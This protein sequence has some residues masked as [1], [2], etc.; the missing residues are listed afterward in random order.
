MADAEA[1]AGAGTQ[2]WIDAAYSEDGV[3][4][5]TLGSMG[6]F[7]RG[8]QRQVNGHEF[9]ADGRLAKRLA[10]LSGG[11]LALAG[12]S[13][14]RPLSA[15]AAWSLANT[16]GTGDENSPFEDRVIALDFSP[17]GEW[18]ATGGGFPSRGGEIYIWNVEDG[19][20]ELRILEAHSDTVCSLAFSPDGS[21]LASGGTIGSPESLRRTG[22][23]NFAPWKG[24]P[25][26]CSA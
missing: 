24:T 17:D 9:S 16:I 12:G 13:R 5:Y 25:A 23:R 10:L 21:Q 6:G 18:L 19:S 2:D 26:M 22:G 1:R 20:E 14:R 7:N 11:R 15:S 8:P 3:L 4:V